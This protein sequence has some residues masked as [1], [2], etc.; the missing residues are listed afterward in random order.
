MN[1][2]TFFIKETNS[3][4]W[5]L[6]STVKMH[7]AQKNLP[8][9]QERLA[10]LGKNWDALVESALEP[11]LWLNR[12]LSPHSCSYTLHFHESHTK[13]IKDTYT[14]TSK[15]FC[16]QWD[17]AIFSHKLI[18]HKIINLKKQSYDSW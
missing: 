1:K 10:Y 15:N 3:K 9:H 17:R 11:D 2:D 5:E 4:L 12:S 7:D 16:S 8:F 14:A 18:S 6:Y 13:E